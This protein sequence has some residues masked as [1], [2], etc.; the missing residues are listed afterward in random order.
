MI[1]PPDEGGPAMDR[2]AKAVISELLTRHVTP[3]GS[4]AAI[5]WDPPDE[6]S[7]AAGA[8]TAL[9]GPAD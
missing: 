9:P 8:A 2:P 1:T 6:S 7:T 5:T 3:S 4:F